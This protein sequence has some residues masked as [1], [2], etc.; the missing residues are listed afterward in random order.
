MY[1]L[2]LPA[3]V[4][5]ALSSTSL[6]YAQVETVERIYVE[7]ADNANYF[8]NTVSESLPAVIG[9][10]IILI[11]GFFISKYIGK[12]VQKKAHEVLDKSGYDEV[13]YDS[14][15]QTKSV[16]TSHAIGATIRWF[17]FLFFVV[18]AVNALEFAELSQALETVW[19]WFPNVIAAMVAVIIGVMITRYISKW[20]DVELKGS[21]LAKTVKSLAKASVFTIVIAVSLTQLGI[22]TTILPIVIAALSVSVAIMLAWGVKD[23]LP[24]TLRGLSNPNS[25]LSLGQKIRIGDYEGAVTNIGLL[26]ISIVTAK[27]ECVIIPMKDIHEKPLVILDEN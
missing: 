16:D 5:L 8:V 22:G 11:A 19:L 26:H 25:K 24:A 12:L 27:N 15:L 4:L 14:K 2:L 3:L 1:K 21:N 7:T 23:F 10:I 13:D 17:V 9:A 20:A 6:A 18:A